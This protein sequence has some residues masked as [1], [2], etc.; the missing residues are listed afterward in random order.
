MASKP[1]HVRRLQKALQ[2]WVQNPG[3]SNF[4]TLV[5]SLYCSKPSDSQMK[6]MSFKLSMLASVM[7]EMLVAVVKETKKNAILW[8]H[9]PQSKGS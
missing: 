3:Q 4:L 7:G 8:M 9:M 2:E 6:K 1:L 5:T